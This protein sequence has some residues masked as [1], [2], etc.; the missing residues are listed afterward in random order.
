MHLFVLVFLTEQVVAG[1]CVVLYAILQA[2]KEVRLWI[3]KLIFNFAH[4]DVI[5]LFFIVLIVIDDTT[6]VCVRENPLN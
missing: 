1:C 6:R 3:A 2:F 5:Y 4:D